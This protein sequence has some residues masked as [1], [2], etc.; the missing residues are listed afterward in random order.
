MMIAVVR[1]DLAPIKRKEER[2]DNDRKQ[3]GLRPSYSDT[4]KQ[5]NNQDRQWSNI[6]RNRVTSLKELNT[7]ERVQYQAEYLI[8]RYFYINLVGNLRVIRRSLI[9]NVF[10]GR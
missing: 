10:K 7:P 1:E 6:Q 2:H 8:D 5:R 9:Q 3:Q 4:L